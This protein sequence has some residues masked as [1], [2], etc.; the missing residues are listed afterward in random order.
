MRTLVTRLRRV[1]ALAFIGTAVACGGEDPVSVQSPETITF[2]PTLNVDLGAMFRSSTGLYTRD[3]VVGEGAEALAGKTIGVRYRG[4]L[5]N[6]TMFDSRT[7]G[8]FSFELGSRQ[9]IDGW[10]Q[11]FSGMRVGGTRQLVIPP[12]LGYGSVANGPI[13]A[14][15]V[16]VFTVELVSVR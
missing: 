12:S 9:V 11:G 15:S 16:L 6:G 1:V 8:A 4:F 14:G 5:S 13:P 2:A 3:L 7:T 10:E